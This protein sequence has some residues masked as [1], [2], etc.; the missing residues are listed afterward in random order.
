MKC[1]AGFLARAE[2]AQE[3]P[4]IAVDVQLVNLTATVRDSG[5]GLVSELA[6]ADFEI[7]EDGAAQTV[8]LFARQKDVPLSVRL[9][10]DFSGSQD[11]FMRRR[12]R[13]IEAMMNESKRY[14]KGGRKH[15]QLGG[16]QHNSTAFRML[17][18]IEAALTADVLIDTVRYTTSEAERK[19]ADSRD[20]YGRR[21]IDRVSAET[22]GMAFNAS[23]DSPKTAF[24]ALAEEL[25]SLYEF[26]CHSTATSQD[27]RFRR[28]EIRSKQGGLKARPKP[29]YYAR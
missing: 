3:P 18:K 27:G 25:H 5:G 26:G 23:R 17:D 15:P 14:E 10:V 11:E 22:G 1:A 9:L 13:D 4:R 29:G 8:R 20:T 12:R 21:V 2:L 16:G 7:I 6:K 24:A 28:L 19:R